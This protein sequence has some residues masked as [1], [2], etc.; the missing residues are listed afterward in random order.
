MKGIDSVRARVV[1]LHE[2]QPEV[3]VATLRGALREAFG[4]VYSLPVEP[5]GALDATAV[6]ALTERNR[7]WKWNYGQKLPFDFSCEARFPWGELRIELAV[8]YGAVCRAAVYSDAM[9]W[10][11][12]PRLETALT[13]SRFDRAELSER[14]RASDLS[15][16]E[17]VAALLAEQGI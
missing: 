11:V 5:I 15:C 12:A 4:E 2:L 10:T 7:S 14:V 1:N 16:A 3:T 13:G 8:E 17:D 9:D 6:D